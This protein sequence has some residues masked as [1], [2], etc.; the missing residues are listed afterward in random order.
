MV[1]KKLLFK[2]EI[3]DIILRNVAFR[4]HAEIVD[5]MPR[6]TGKTAASVLIEPT[7]EGWVI[8]TNDPNALRLEF[9]TKPHLIEP[10]KKKA[11]AWRDDGRP[12]FSVTPPDHFAKKVRHPGTPALNIFQKAWARIPEFIDDEI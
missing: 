5:N 4:T 12:N 11:L 1:G 9:G 3:E 6:K 8:G 10:K 7:D 2:D